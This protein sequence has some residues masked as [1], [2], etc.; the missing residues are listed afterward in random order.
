[1]LPN[2]PLDVDGKLIRVGARV[3]YGSDNGS[4]LRISKIWKITDCVGGLIHD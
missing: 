1:M 4:Y 2:L 3:V